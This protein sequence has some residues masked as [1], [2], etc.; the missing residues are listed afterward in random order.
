M[1]LSFQA[2]HAEIGSRIVPNA[3]RLHLASGVDKVAV[4]AWVVANRDF[5]YAF[6]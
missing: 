4:R 5:F 3:V 6:R 2:I 1:V